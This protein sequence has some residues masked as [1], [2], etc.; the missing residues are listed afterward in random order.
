MSDVRSETLTRS[1]WIDAIRID[2]T[3]PQELG[4]RVSQMRRLYQNADEL[5]VW[6]GE[7]DGHSEFAMELIEQSDA[8]PEEDTE[9]IANPTNHLEIPDVVHEIFSGV[10]ISASDS[11]SEIHTSKLV[12]KATQILPG[13][14]MMDSSLG[15]P[16]VCSHTTRGLDCLRQAAHVR[17]DLLEIG[18]EIP[19]TSTMWP[20]LEVGIYRSQRDWLHYLGLPQSLSVWT[21]REVV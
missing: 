10:A 8:Y 11:F 16:R 21:E 4:R 12:E 6:L 13:T 9:V 1:L 15:D 3:N 2:Q 7:A 14:V 18:G 5:L 19:K 17:L 20:Q